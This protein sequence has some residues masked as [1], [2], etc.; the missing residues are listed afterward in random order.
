MTPSP[1]RGN[2]GSNRKSLRYL[3][4]AG[5]VS[6]GLVVGALFS[7][8]GIAGAQTED[9]T[10][11][12]TTE[13]DATESTERD[14]ERGHKGRK[15][16]GARMSSFLE[17]SGLTIEQVREGFE[18]DQSLAQIAEA[19]GVDSDGVKADLV[20][21]KTERINAMVEAGRITQ[22]EADAK[23][24]E[25]DDKIDEKLNLTPSERQALREERRAERQAERNAAE[26]GDTEEETLNS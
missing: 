6:G 22:E 14:G 11:D 15:G 19:N 23:I 2:G 9:T 12:A 20:A 7:P 10:P 3:T 18:A 21:A 13:A 8:I 17:T 1:N 5:L 26:A 4:G 16:K 24:A 25:L